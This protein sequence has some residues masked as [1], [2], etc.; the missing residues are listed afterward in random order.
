MPINFLKRK[1]ITYLQEFIHDSRAIGIILLANTFLALIIA[2]TVWGEGFIS[3]LHTEW[4]VLHHWQLPHTALHVINDGLMAIFFLLVGMEIKRELVVGELASVKK[5]ILPIGAAI[6]GMLAPAVL[7]IFFNKGG[8]FQQGWGVPTAT[9]IAFSLGVA[10]M[11]GRKFPV[12]LKIF[13][14]ALAI[15]DDLGAILIIAFF[16]GGAINGLYLL[17]GAGILL[18]MHWLNRRQYK[19]GM[20]HILLGILLWFCMYNS[21]IHATIAG[22]L[23]AF[24]IPNQYLAGLEMKLHN[25]V[26][27]FILPIFALANTAIVLNGGMLQDAVA[28]S[29][30]WGVFVGLVLGKPLGITLACWLLVKKKAAVLP[31]G[32]NWYHII[33]A[34][35]LAGIGFTMSIFIT[36]LAFA[37]ARL[38]DISKVAILVSA[39]SSV[40][41]GFLWFSVGFL[42]RIFS[43][44][45]SERQTN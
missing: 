22:V 28:S 16:Y 14:M 18:L 4:A 5:A 41:L 7:Y 33:G 15:I 44:K 36:S 23:F 45:Q 39:L 21:G 43:E 29:L 17:L 2:N 37:E 26:N 8:Q 20:W 25:P 42:Q 10:S 38:Q 31:R 13:L 32:I 1:F 11:L 3:L 6:G 24:M 9:D 40:I 35:I 30:A 27:F 34:G 12:N 19:F